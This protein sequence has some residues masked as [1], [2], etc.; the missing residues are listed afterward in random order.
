M[1][2]V[3]MPKHLPAMITLAKILFFSY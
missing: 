2:K 1:P 3:T